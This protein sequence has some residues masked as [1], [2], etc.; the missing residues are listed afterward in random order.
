MSQFRA[1]LFELFQTENKAYV[2]R[3]SD[4]Q[5]V[6]ALT[7]GEAIAVYLVLTERENA[8]SILEAAAGPAGLQWLHRAEARLSPL[9]RPDVGISSELRL[10]DLERTLPPDPGEGW[11]PLP[12]P[13][14]LHWCVTKYCPHRCV[15]CY[16]E[17]TLGAD[18]KD[19]VITRA[20]LLR[21]FREAAVLGTKTFLVGGSEP[22]LRP[23]LPEIMGDAQ[24][25]GI[26][27]L[28]TT[29]HP[30]TPAL[31]RRLADAGVAHISLS[32]DTLDPDQ[33]RTL[34]GNPHFPTQ[35]RQSVA[36]LNA[37]GVRFSFQC[38][39]TSMNERDAVSVA[40]FAETA[41]AVVVQIV[42]FE[43]VRKPIGRY[44]NQQMEVPDRGRVQDLAESIGATFSG[45][46]VEMFEKLGSG[47]HAAFNCDI[48]M[49]K[50]FFLPDGAIHRCYKLVEDDTLRG[51]DLRACSVAAAWHDAGFRHQI[52]P[53]LEKYSDS[54]CGQC[55]KFSNCHDEGRCVY[56]ASIGHGTYFAPDR[57]CKGPFAAASSQ[58]QFVLISPIAGA[59]A[60]G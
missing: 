10:Q 1:A 47:A 22:F 44:S 45:V 7:K 24:S 25:C 15:Y 31:A 37:A 54:A 23:D 52:S 46:K 50:M 28:V 4:D 21:I 17:P 58:R 14:V 38:V 32:V 55:G 36:N 34:I 60:S 51:L 9:L 2:R 26:T 35:V 33:S 40:E 42:P 43:P 16:A 39:V 11:R 56:Q 29:K 12:G 41:G 8:S 5:I 19:S 57:Q 53:P 6:A 13:R 48:G 18:A 27:P 30:I 59:A 49:T 3:K 20:E